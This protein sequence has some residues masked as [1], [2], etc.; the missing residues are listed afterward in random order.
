MGPVREM[1]RQ[2]V[3]LPDAPEAKAKTRKRTSDVLPPLPRALDTPAFQRVWARWIASRSQIRKPLR[4][5]AAEEQLE[6]LEAMGELKAIAQL[7]RAIAGSW[8]G[9]VF[10]DASGTYKPNSAKQERDAEFALKRRRLAQQAE[11]FKTLAMKQNTADRWWKL[12]PPAQQRENFEAY[13]AAMDED[14][15]SFQRRYFGS[16]PSVDWAYENRRGK[17]SN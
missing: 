10:V 3:L 13:L 5:L 8:Q 15:A 11:D 7:K 2:G 6:A 12:L 9:C 16:R 17:S 1:D 14:T 4:S